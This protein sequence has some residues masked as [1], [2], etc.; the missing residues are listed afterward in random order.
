VAQEPEGSSPHSQQPTAGPCPEP[1]EYNLHPPSQSP[2]DPFW[3]HLPTYALVFQVVSFQWTWPI[4]APNIPCT[5]CVLH[6]LNMIWSTIPISNF[7]LETGIVGSNPSQHMDVCPRLCCA[8]LC[9]QRPSDGPAPLRNPAKYWK[10]RFSNLKKRRPGLFK[11][12]VATGK[13]RKQCVITQHL[14]Y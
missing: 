14:S 6:F 2:E 11:N 3:S 10:A 12:R 1:V 13:K 4:Q 9:R 5:K 7:R 8:V